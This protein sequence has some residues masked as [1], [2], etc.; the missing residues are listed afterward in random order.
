MLD[1]VEA[2]LGL[3]EIEVGMT[4][5]IRPRIECAVCWDRRPPSHGTPEQW[6]GT[7][8]TVVRVIPPEY[9]PTYCHPYVVMPLDGP[10]VGKTWFCTRSEL[11]VVG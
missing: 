7:P 2:L 3:R 9:R 11:E 10:F 8:C 4:V 5:V 1:D 6:D